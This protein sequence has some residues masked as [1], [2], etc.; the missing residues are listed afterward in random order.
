M[1]YSLYNDYFPQFRYGASIDFKP[2]LTIK[3]IIS[4]TLG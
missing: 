2:I 1:Q 3:L 4:G